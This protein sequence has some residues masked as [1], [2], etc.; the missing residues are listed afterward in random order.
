MTLEASI[1]MN[2]PIEFEEAEKLSEELFLRVMK[3]TDGMISLVGLSSWQ[4]NVVLV[5]HVL[6]LAGGMGLDEMLDDEM[7]ADPGYVLTIKAF[8]EIGSREM[9]EIL[10]EGIA[11][12]TSIAIG[13]DT[14]SMRD[15]DALDEDFYARERECVTQ[16]G[17]YIAANKLN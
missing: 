14:S 17:R 15:F 5:Y 1:P 6:G 8:R 7:D 2:N 9:A 4:Q 3:K 13:V 11:I 10:E 16:M 12:K